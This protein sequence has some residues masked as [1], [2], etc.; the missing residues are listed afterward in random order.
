MKK[1]YIEYT[2]DA[3]ESLI[4]DCANYGGE[5]ISDAIGEIADNAVDIYTSDLLDWAARNYD[6]CDDAVKNG[7]VDLNNCDNVMVKLAQAGQYEYYSQMLYE[8]RK[9]II[10]LYAFDRLDSDEMPD[11][12]AEILTDKADTLDKFSEI[13]DLIA[14]YKENHKDE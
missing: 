6:Y 10:L 3:D 7:L 12:L 8:N 2:N 1:Q 11:E 13:D 5:Y 4:Q 14:E 9:A